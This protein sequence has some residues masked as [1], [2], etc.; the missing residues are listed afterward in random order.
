MLVELAWGIEGATPMGAVIGFFTSFAPGYID[1][2]HAQYDEY[3]EQLEE[4][5]EKKD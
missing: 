4:S 2:V 3:N 1:D 5:K